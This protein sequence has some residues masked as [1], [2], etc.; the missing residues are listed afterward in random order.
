M[1][2]CIACRDI[3]VQD[4]S[5]L[6]RKL[7]MGGTLISK[8]FHRPDCVPVCVQTADWHAVDRRCLVCQLKTR[9]PPCGIKFD[10]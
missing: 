7:R 3:Y 8:H 9:G 2:L 5:V 1:T 10:V 6:T 4:L